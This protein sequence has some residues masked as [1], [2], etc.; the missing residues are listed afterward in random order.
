M[1]DQRGSRNRAHCGTYGQPTETRRHNSR[2]PTLGRVLRDQRQS[3][4]KGCAE[5]E[6]YQDA[7]QL[8][9]CYRSSCRAQ[10]RREPD[11]GGTRD[12]DALAAETV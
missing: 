12:Y 11:R 9:H 4:W 3:V 2:P 6:P 8:K 7:Q 1:W 5:P 10:K